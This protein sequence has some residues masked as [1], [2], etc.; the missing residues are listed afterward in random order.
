MKHLIK[1]LI[2][3]SLVVFISLICMI[4]VPPQNPVV[5]QL[6]TWLFWFL[7]GIIF[8]SVWVTE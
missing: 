1:I 8:L 4:F 6:A 5:L 2:S 3:I 7:G